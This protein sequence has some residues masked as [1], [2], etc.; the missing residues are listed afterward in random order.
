MMYIVQCTNL[1]SSD[2]TIKLWN[3]GK[4]VCLA[5]L[6]LESG[7]INDISIYTKPSDS[8]MNVVDE[9]DEVQS[10]YV[11]FYKT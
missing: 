8:Q 2:G 10:F 3:C 9:G 4:A 11:L 1:I 5:T 7:G 6:S